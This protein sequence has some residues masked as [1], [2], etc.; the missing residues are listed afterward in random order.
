LFPKFKGCVH[1]AEIRER[2][3]SVV[4]LLALAAAELLRRY[5]ITL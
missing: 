4:L 1:E 5:N 2:G 3:R